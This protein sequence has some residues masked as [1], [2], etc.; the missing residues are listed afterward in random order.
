MENLSIRVPESHDE[1]WIFAS[2]SAG[3]GVG[4]VHGDSVEESGMQGQLNDKSQDCAL[5]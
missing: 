5:Q 2:G 4:A 1:R 3:A